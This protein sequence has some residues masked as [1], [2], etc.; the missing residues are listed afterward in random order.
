MDAT[1][2]GNQ[3]CVVCDDLDQV[4]FCPAGKVCPTQS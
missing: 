2:T 3:M 1:E 4:K